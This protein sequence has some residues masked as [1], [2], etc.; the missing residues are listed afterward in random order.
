MCAILSARR[1][2]RI[3]AGRFGYAVTGIDADASA[4]DVGRAHA[5]A[6]GLVIDYHNAGIEQ[7]RAIGERFDVALALEIVEHVTD[8][9]TFFAAL[10]ALVRPGGVFI[11]ATL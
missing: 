2:P 1:R 6:S 8:R 11:G 9:E 10:G 5:E 4:I 7:I 3:L